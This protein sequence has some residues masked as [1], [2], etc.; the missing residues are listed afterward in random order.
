MGMREGSDGWM[1]VVCRH[2]CTAASAE[3]PRQGRLPAR[4]SN[5]RQTTSQVAPLAASQAS[6]DVQN[7]GADV[8]DDVLLNASVLK[9][10]DPVPVRPLRSSDAPLLNVPRT[11]TVARRLFSVAAPHTWNSLPSDV[12]SCR[13]VDTFKR[14]LTTH[15]FRH[16][17]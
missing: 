8:Q 5:R 16:K 17:S 14:H 1:Y 2:R 15:L 12:R 11:R 13:T 7:F 6:S 3:Q 4:R 9:W 10:P